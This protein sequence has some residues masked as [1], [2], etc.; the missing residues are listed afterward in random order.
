MARLTLW[1]IAIAL[2]GLAVGCGPSR[3]DARTFNEPSLEKR[4]LIASWNTEFK[5]AVLAKVQ[6]E[7]KKDNAHI[8]IIDPRDLHKKDPAD[9]D[10][11]VILDRVWMWRLSSAY[12]SF[13]KR[14]EERGRLV[15]VPTAGDPDWKPIDKGVDV[16]TATSRPESVDKVAKKL[17]VRI[18]ARLAVQFDLLR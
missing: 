13:L 1:G 7:V 10:A 11:I 8:E 18:R 17:I 6:E 16:V 5:R 9:Y 15:L 2:A 4:V 14:V 12:R 3:L